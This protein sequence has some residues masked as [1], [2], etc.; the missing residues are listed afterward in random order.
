MKRTED[1]KKYMKKYNETTKSVTNEQTEKTRAM[2]LCLKCGKNFSSVGIYN[3][4]CSN[5]AFNNERSYG[6][7]VQEVL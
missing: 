1:K 4:L 6:H 7:L 5:C 3:R 2:R